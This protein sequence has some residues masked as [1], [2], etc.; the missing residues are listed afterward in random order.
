[1]NIEQLRHLCE[2]IE[3]GSFEIAAQKLLVNEAE[4][5][6][7]IISLEVE[8]GIK[9]IECEEESKVVPSFECLQIISLVKEI[10]MNCQ[11]IEED[12]KDLH[13]KKL[14]NRNMMYETSLF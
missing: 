9:L 14:D 2:V 1:V 11:E 10:V 6:E 3:S 8:F 5:K 4:I 7:S 12:I 13:K